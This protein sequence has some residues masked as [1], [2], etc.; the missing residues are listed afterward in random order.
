MICSPGSAISK[1]EFDDL[2]SKGAGRRHFTMRRDL[3][4]SKVGLPDGKL[5]VTA[6][7]VAAF[8]HR[9]RVRPKTRTPTRSMN[10]SLP[11]R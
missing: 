10:A 2:K 4:P 1:V 6:W 11:R 9:G 3:P 5:H 8:T 7:T